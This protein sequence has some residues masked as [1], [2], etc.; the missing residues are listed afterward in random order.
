MESIGNLLPQVMPKL[1][2]KTNKFFLLAE[3]ITKITREPVTRRLREVKQH[4]WAA[5]TALRTLKE[6]IATSGR[7]HNPAAYYTSLFR[8]FKESGQC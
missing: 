8:K 2:K 1:G 7:P 6:R 5:E 4:Q 3:E